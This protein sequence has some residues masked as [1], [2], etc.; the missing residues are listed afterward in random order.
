MWAL[1][2]CPSSL[3]RRKVLPTR[4]LGSRIG[5]ARFARFGGDEV[6]SSAGRTV[7]IGSSLRGAVV[8]IGSSLREDA[9]S[10][11]VR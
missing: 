5:R 9:T 11:A 7:D 1:R 6:V 4:S 10:G 8:D 2:R 3:S